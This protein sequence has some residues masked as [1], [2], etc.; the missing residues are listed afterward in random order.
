MLLCCSGCQG[1]R[2]SLPSTRGT[3]QKHG[4]TQRWAK[5]TRLLSGRTTSEGVSGTGLLMID[6]SVNSLQPQWMLHLNIRASASMDAAC[7]HFS[8][9]IGCCVCTLQLASAS[10]DAGAVHYNKCRHQWNWPGVR[11]NV[12]KA[13]AELACLTSVIQRHCK[14]GLGPLSVEQSA[15]GHAS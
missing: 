4:S 14:K 15:S 8:A 12:Q 7:V 1:S 6:L 13:P 3:V 9:S 11:V 10:M 5:H 2:Q